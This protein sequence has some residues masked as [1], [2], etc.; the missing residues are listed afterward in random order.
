MT[1]LE[2]EATMHRDPTR[3][4]M[5]TVVAR[6]GAKYSLHK[7]IFISRPGGLDWKEPPDQLADGS[8]ASYNLD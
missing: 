5:I 6:E 2:K 1:Q 7:N 3:P 4:N 8:E